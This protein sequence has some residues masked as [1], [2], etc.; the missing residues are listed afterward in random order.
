VSGC[1]GPAGERPALVAIVGSGCAGTLV[2]ANL[3]RR[4]HGALRI[5]LV[6]RSGRF[7]PGVAYATEDPQHL[8]NV[9]AE[10]MSA[11]CDEPSHFAEWAAER[12]RGLAPASYLPRGVY[13]EYLRSVLA[14]S[15]AR[16]RPQ[17]RTLELVSGEAA[18]L[19]RTPNELELRLAD[20]RRIVCD[21]V[22]LAT[23]PPEGAAIEQLPSDPRVIADPWAAA[24]LGSSVASGL[25]LVIGTGLSGVDATLSITAGRGRV[26][27]LSRGGRL[28]Y[29]HLPGLHTP[30]PPP[31]IPSGSLRLDELERIVREHV[32]AAQRRGHDWRAAFDGLRPI[33]P[34]LW[35]ALSPQERRRFLRE[36][37][38][39]W[40]I[41]RH[42]MA[43]AVGARLRALLDS[44]ALE[45][46]AGSIVAARASSGGVE[47]DVAPSRPG[48][49]R[50]IACER[51]VVCTGAG[52]DVRQSSNPIL[53]ALLADGGA[54]ADELALGVRCSADGA[55]LDSDG[56]ADGRLFTL[57]ALR[58]G[59]LWESTAVEE[60]RAQAERLAIAI[61]RSLSG[62]AP[63]PAERASSNGKALIGVTT[64]PPVGG[65]NRIEVP[66]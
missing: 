29:A 51:V 59:E 37:L 15:R 38:R 66:R 19:K 43:P 35:A 26:L 34:E 60:I 27:A 2:A 55:L 58:R 53:R 65:R 7:G 31:P 14:D 64:R 17:R 4:A 61:E 33:T 3:L 18:G 21:R 12:I 52:K 45:H 39:S 30:T 11:F 22:V 32:T 5:V 41:R 28:P 13:G 56:H 16:A 47:V 1:S 50:T 20:G 8:L 49:I 44:G 46:S 54:S 25:T 62:S 40:E 63:S 10:R 9:P 42:R 24:A 36:R 57:G 6:E 23:G 48:P